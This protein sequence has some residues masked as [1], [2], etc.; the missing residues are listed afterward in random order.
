M[1]FGVFDGLHPGHISFLKQARALG[2]YLVAVVARN[3]AVQILK[4]RAT[5]RSLAERIEALKVSGTVDQVL[6]G[7]LEEGSWEVLDGHQ[8]NIIALGYDQHELKKDL[9]VVLPSKSFSCSIVVLEAHEPN[10]HHSSLLH[11]IK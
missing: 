9:E 2:D 4:K 8:P 6:I 1:V 3:E 11:K 10:V 5:R 7:D